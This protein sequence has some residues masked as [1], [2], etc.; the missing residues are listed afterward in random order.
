[1]CLCVCMYECLALFPFL[2]QFFKYYSGTLLSLALL[3][4]HNASGA[5]C[6]KCLGLLNFKILENNFLKLMI[7]DAKNLWNTV[8]L[9]NLRHDRDFDR[10]L[11]S[12]KTECQK[13]F[14]R[15]RSYNLLV[16]AILTV[17]NITFL[18]CEILKYA[19]CW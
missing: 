3:E 5:A 8:A 15:L 2:K 1:M 19:M 14:I 12:S 6:P 10:I 11:H 13:I 17:P 7:S 4:T 9:S 18:G 16:K